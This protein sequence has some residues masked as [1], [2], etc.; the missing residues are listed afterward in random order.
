MCE[1]VFECECAYIRQYI[2]EDT[3]IMPKRKTNKH[4]NKHKTVV[5]VSAEGLCEG[6]E[7][8]YVLNFVLHE[9]MICSKY[10]SF[11]FFFFK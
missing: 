11:K 5:A 2:L 9:E 1:L 6:K 7:L 4:Q 10:T 3:Q 8:L